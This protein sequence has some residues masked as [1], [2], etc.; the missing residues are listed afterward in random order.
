MFHHLGIVVDDLARSV[1]LYEA[2]LAPLG[3][4]PIENE[5]DW[6]VFSAG[7]DQPTLWLGSVRPGFWSG[8]HKAGAAPLHL[9][10][11]APDRSAVDVFHAAALAQGATDNGAP[12]PRKS[13]ASFYSAFVIDLDGNNLEATLRE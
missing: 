10:F 8:K 13:W 7:P 5:K 4:K 3:I 11:A 6:V 2:C 9:A 12:G 1:A